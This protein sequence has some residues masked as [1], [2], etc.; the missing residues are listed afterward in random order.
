MSYNV[1]L[2]GQST[3]TTSFEA[4]KNIVKAGIATFAESIAKPVRAGL[5]RS[6]K[7]TARVNADRVRSAAKLASGVKLP[8]TTGDVS[9]NVGGFAF[10]IARK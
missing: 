9:G 3:D 6:P 4:A 10:S 8:K 5:Y 7:A 2:N 1:T